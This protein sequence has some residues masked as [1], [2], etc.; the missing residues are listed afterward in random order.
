MA[1]TVEDGSG[2]ANADSYVSVA[3]ADTYH[4]AH[5][6]PSS[7]SGL[8]T[9][10]K[11]QYLK[12]ATTYL[13]SVYY[14]QWQGYRTNGLDQGLDHPRAAMYDRDGNLRPE[15]ELAKELTDAT[16]ILANIRAGGT[17]LLAT[18]T[19]PGTL[20]SKKIKVDVIEIEKVYPG[21]QSSVPYFREV[22]LLIARLTGGT[23]LVS[24][25]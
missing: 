1:I 18:Q 10:L 9:S 8:S 6:N 11:E 25:G 22:S 19:T 20:G 15:D 24:R 12:E 2:V 7:W 3:D 13:D 14:Y 23:S 4:T 5:G 21:G 16:C 17:T